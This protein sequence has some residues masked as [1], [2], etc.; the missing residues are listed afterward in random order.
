[1][2]PRPLAVGRVVA[3]NLIPPVVTKRRS[4]DERSCADRHS[5]GKIRVFCMKRYGVRTA[6]FI[7]TLR[8]RCRIIHPFHPLRDHEIDVIN[9]RKSWGRHYVDHVDSNGVLAGIPLDWTDAVEPDLFLSFSKGRSHFRFEEL[10]RLSDLVG[11]L[12]CLLR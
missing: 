1:M 7:H 3:E 5:S 8:Q 9:Y 10:L 12:N 11:D 4:P 6:P 2:F